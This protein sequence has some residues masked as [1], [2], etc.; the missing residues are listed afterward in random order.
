MREEHSSAP[1]SLLLSPCR[2]SSRISDAT[3]RAKQSSI[4]RPV[5]PM[6]WR[7]DESWNGRYAHRALALLP[8][9]LWHRPLPDLP[10]GTGDV[11]DDEAMETTAR[12][13]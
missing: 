10:F 2:Q 4:A 7:D 1:R 9:A 12:A 8:V 13:N 5:P 11:L 6:H 3:P